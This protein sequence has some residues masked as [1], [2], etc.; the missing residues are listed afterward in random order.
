MDGLAGTLALIA[1]DAVRD[2]RASRSTRSGCCSSSRSRSRCACLGFLIFNFRP[3]QARARLHGR[4]GQPGA[5]VHAR[6]ARP[7]DE[8]EGGGD[9]R[10][11]ARPAAARAGGADPRHGARRDDADGRGPADP[12]GRQ[13]P[14]LAPARPRRPLRA[15]DGRSCS[16]RSPPALGGTALAYSVLGDY[17]ITLVGVLVTF[18]LLVQFAGFL[19]D[20]ERGAGDEVVPGGW[21]LRTV[22]LHRRRLFEV[23]VD[24]VLISL[25][26]AAAYALLVTGTGT[27]VPAPRRSAVALPLI[28][29]ARYVAFL[30]A[31]PLPG[32]L[33][34]R[35]LARG[36]G[37]RRRRRSS[38]RRSRSGSSR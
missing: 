14:H 10:G 24:F 18:A 38:R 4:L 25:S 12:P 35:R 5:R 11:D 29:V 22:V 9:D 16:P 8:L 36:G 37:D 1:R 30:A 13:G 21:M 2:R 31:R 19:V 32:H 27:H 6:R 20:L 3:G 15:P 28:L 7:G 17:R 26:F 34:L 23:L 33:A